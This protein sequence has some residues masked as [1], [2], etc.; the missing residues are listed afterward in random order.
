MKKIKYIFFV[1]LMLPMLVACN[2][3]DVVPDNIATIETVFRD[4]QTAESYLF[5]CYSFMPM[6]NNSSSN[7]GISFSD[8]FCVASTTAGGITT[9][10]LLTETG[11]SSSNPSINLWDGANG[12]TSG[13]GLFTGIRCCNLFLEQIDNIPD[14]SKD[15]A[16]RWKAEAKFLK[17]YYHWYLFQLYGPI[18]I[19]DV[20]LSINATDEEMRVY[21]A[22]VDEVVDY[23]IGQIDASLSDLPKDVIGR[24]LEELG[25]VTRPAAMAIKARILVT[26]AS[27]LFNGNPDYKNFKD[28]RGVSLFPTGDRNLDKWKRAAKACKEAIDACEGAGLGLYNFVKPN[29]S[30]ILNDSVRLSAQPGMILGETTNNNEAIWLQS[31]AKGSQNNTVPTKLFFGTSGGATTFVSPVEVFSVES[32]SLNSAELFY[33][34]HGLPMDE[35]NS[36]P[37][38]SRFTPDPNFSTRTDHKYWV[39]EKYQTALFNINREPRYYGSLAFDGANW[40][41]FGIINQETQYFV[42]AMNAGLGRQS[43][44]GLFIKKYV[45]YKAALSGGQI[46]SSAP[47]ISYS[48]YS[49]PIMRMADLYL[50]YAEALNEVANSPADNEDIFKYVDMIRVRAGLKGV[51]SSWGSNFSTQPEK[52]TTQGGMREIIQR[53][54]MIELA[55]EGQGGFDRRRWKIMDKLLTKGSIRG[56]TYTALTADEYAKSNVVWTT[57]FQFRDYF[58]P[59][60]IS[61]L[62]VNPNLVQNPGWEN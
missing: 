45:P 16:A 59:I 7:P 2:Y 9:N 29:S 56:F 1:A 10:R 44:T 19:T 26:A 11:N 57:N 55:Y 17:A 15:E 60:K 42:K 6:H 13:K 58:W 41:G 40:F 37:Y 12:I 62:Q 27:P 21:R 52:F 18:P 20:N 32:A 8:E 50:L 23:I 25:R 31:N 33:T 43:L 34:S 39:K 35:D 46:A 4:R 61:D 14:I 3:L 53:E 48:P 47:T 51:R 22:P 36:F 49:W 24:E 28:K 38:A 5:T 54:R 30:M